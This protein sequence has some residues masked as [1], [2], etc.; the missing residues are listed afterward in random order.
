MPQFFVTLTWNYNHANNDQ[1]ISEFN[2][3]K[4][5]AQRKGTISDWVIEYQPV[6]G[7]AHAHCLYNTVYTSPDDIKYAFKKR[8]LHIHPV[9]VKKGTVEYVKGY[10]HKPATKTPLS[11]DNVAPRVDE[12]IVEEH[13]ITSEEDSSWAPTPEWKAQEV[14]SVTRLLKPI[15]QIT[16][17]FDFF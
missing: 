14:T 2:L 17:L 5:L 16:D 13:S 12:D 8:G 1:R 6:S 7:H 9:K 11:E 15:T 10:I 3:W 4:D